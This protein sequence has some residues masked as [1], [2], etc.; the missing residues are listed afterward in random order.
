[1]IILTNSYYNEMQSYLKLPTTSSYPLEPTHDELSAEFEML[2]EYKSASDTIVYRSAKFKLL[3]GVGAEE[4]NK[5]KFRVVKLSNSLSDNELKSQ[6]I[7]AIN[8]YFEVSN[9]EFGETFYFT[10]L[11]SYIHQ[12]LGSAIGSI[13][14]L[15]RS[16]NGSFGDLF[17]VRAEPNELFASTATVNDIE[18]VEKITSQTLRADR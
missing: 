15:P 5:A 6:I 8:N 1:M 9:W 13:V 18:I 12:R 17:Q 7:T 11:S 10:E 4:Q 3:F 14:I 2:D 16:T